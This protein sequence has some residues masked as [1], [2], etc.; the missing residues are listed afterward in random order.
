MKVVLNEK[1]LMNI[2]SESIAKV[3]NENFEAEAKKGG[4]KKKDGREKEVKT[5]KESN[6]RR[7]DVIRILKKDGINNAAIMRAVWKPRS[8][9]QEDAYRG[10]WYQCRDGKEGP[11]GAP[12]RFSTKDI[13]KIYSTINND[14]V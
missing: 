14:I 10:Y 12:R 4:D 11:S 8:K 5:D 1:R 13:N 9:K 6:A 2:I 7:R 3:I